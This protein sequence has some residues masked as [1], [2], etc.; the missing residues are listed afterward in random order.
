MNVFASGY[1]DPTAAGTSI[2]GTHTTLAAG[3]RVGTAITSFNDATLAPGEAWVW[4][5][6]ALNSAA[7]IVMQLAVEVLR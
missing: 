4:D 7:D 1:T 2:F 3:S 6:D 5:V